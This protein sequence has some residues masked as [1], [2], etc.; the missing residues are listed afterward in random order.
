MTFQYI[1]L[2]GGFQNKELMFFGLL[3][4]IYLGVGDTCAAILGRLWG[5]TKIKNN[6]NKTTEGTVYFTAS[7]FLALLVIANIVYPKYL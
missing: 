5:K 2:Q 7:T 3:G 6:S 1:L 4:L